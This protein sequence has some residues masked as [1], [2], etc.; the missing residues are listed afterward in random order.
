M[1]AS[2]AKFQLLGVIWMGVTCG[3]SD[4]RPNILLLFPDEW[5]FDWA[6][7]YYYKDLDIHLPVFNQ[8]VEEGT[9]F[10]NTAVAAPLC[11][12]SR[13]CIAGG[14]EYDEAGV[15]TNSDDY[16]LDHV[17]IYNLMEDAGYHIMMAGKDDLTKASGCGIDGSYR[18]EEL[19]FSAQRRCKGKIDMIEDYPKVTDPFAVYLSEMSFPNPLNS[20]LSTEFDIA[21]YWQKHICTEPVHSCPIAIS[22]HDGS[23]YDNYVTALTLDLMDDIPDLDEP[24]FLQVNFEG[25][26]PPFIITESMNQSVNDRVMP[27]P[28]ESNLSAEEI[29]VTR[30][31]YTAT[32]ENIDAQMSIVLDKLKALGEYE[33]TIICI[34]SDHGE[35]LG[36]FNHFWKSVP[37]VASTNVPLACMGP[38]IQKGQIVETYVTNMDLAGT[39]LDYAEAE[40]AEVMTTESLRPFLEG[41]WSDEEHEYREYVSSGL[42]GWRAIIQQ[43]SATVTWKFICCQGQC[44]DRHF[45]AAGSTQMVELLFNVKEDLYE[46]NNLIDDHGEV[47]DR[48][49]AYMK[50]DF[51]VP[52][53]EEDVE[54]TLREKLAEKQ[55]A[56]SW[57][58]FFFM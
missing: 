22:V 58:S 53:T 24:W 41:T 56:A 20:T 6:D 3:A 44:A 57:L 15:L 21:H 11:A 29:A 38:G 9:R 35:M 14:L 13:S 5:R 4:S 37:W 43:E 33:E 49:R 25:P 18:A 10:I 26:H 12:P 8:V 28:M 47:A 31:D 36:D 52:K 19:G 27:Y 40:K 32:I 54:D 51:C 39:F 48:M 42:N 23:Y 50:E 45:G 1:M 16:P 30:R 7:Q 2:S 34:S 55:S 46:M 17:T